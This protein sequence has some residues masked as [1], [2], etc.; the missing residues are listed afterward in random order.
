MYKIEGT[1]EN[2]EQQLNGI[3]PACKRYQEGK[4][5]GTTNP[6]WTGCVYRKTRQ[7]EMSTL[8]VTNSVLYINRGGTYVHGQGRYNVGNRN[9][10]GT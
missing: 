4:C 6:V 8:Q 10:S 5:P 9:I 7:A 2:K 1:A 3:C